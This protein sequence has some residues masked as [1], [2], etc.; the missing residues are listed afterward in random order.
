MPIRLPEKDVVYEDAGE[1]REK[2]DAENAAA[3]DK[4]KASAKRRKKKLV[5]KPQKKV[6]ARE[7]KERQSGSP[8]VSRMI[9]QM[10]SRGMSGLDRDGVNASRRRTGR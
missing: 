9:E 4:A 5:F 7:K 2:W 3:V 8:S 6:N 1:T 10:K